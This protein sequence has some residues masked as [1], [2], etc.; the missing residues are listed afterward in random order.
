MPKKAAQTLPSSPS[1]S[2]A[3]VGNA[4]AQPAAV[5]APSNAN[6]APSLAKP[7]AK[8]QKTDGKGADAG[9]PVASQSTV[10]DLLDW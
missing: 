2:L 7:E 5:P 6:A 3:G 9:K 8:E 4:L 10:L 1:G